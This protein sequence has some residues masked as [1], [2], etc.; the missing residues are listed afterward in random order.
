VVDATVAS[1]GELKV[2]GN[3]EKVNQVVAHGGELTVVK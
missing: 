1:G 3:P 2:Y